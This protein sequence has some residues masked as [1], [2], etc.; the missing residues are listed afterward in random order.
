LLGL[1]RQD[2]TA[3]DFELNGSRRSD[4]ITD[5]FLSVYDPS[6]LPY[7]H[8]VRR[9]R[10]IPGAIRQFAMLGITIGAANRPVES[11][12]YSRWEESTVRQLLGKAWRFVTRRKL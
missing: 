7:R 5:P 12:F 6:T 8:A 10:W 4:Q 2:E 11:E 9:G 3:W 1:L